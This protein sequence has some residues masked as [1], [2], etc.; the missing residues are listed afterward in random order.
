M[1]A[2]S[3]Y[4]T[5]SENLCICVYILHNIYQWCFTEN[6]KVLLTA[7]YRCGFPLLTITCTATLGHL[8]TAHEDDDC[9]HRVQKIT[10]TQFIY[11]RHH[12]VVIRTS[13]QFRYVAY[14]VIPLG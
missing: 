1:L 6:S 5:W 2:D 3:G 9:L 8:V 10:C 12:K 11:N 7:I 4:A 14:T 13:F